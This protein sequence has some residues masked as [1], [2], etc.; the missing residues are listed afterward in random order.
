MKTTDL[1][2]NAISPMFEGTDIHIVEVEYVKR[3]DGMHLIVYIDKVGGI[4][5]EDCERVSR[6][7]DPVIE[8]LNPT[9]DASYCLDV[10][11]YGLDKPLKHDWQFDK[12]LNQKVSVKLYKKVD[13]LK[14]FD[15]ILKSYKDVYKFDIDGKEIE[16]T[17]DLV[18][19]VLPYIE[20]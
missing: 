13:E 14:E 11:S 12:Y 7:I 2:F 8:E 6:S 19:Y 5:L 18:A 17:K 10:S 9:N 3:V 16:I 4:T 20:F 1:V 15:A